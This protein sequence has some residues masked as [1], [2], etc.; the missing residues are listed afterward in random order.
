MS[1]DDLISGILG[2][3]GPEYNSVV[4][5]ITAKQCFISLQEVQFLLMRYESRLA[6]HNTTAMV[7]LAHASANFIGS[8]M[9]NNRG[10]FIGYNAQGSRGRYKG[11][12]RDRNGSRGRL[13]CQLC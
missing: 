12:G 1:N 2:A 5:T 9:F 4:V 8:N 7:D 13:F 3:L 6:H 10:G 11:R